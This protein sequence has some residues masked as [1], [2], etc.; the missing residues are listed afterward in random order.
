MGCFYT[1]AEDIFDFDAMNIFL[2]KYNISLRGKRFVQCDKPFVN[3]LQW[4]DSIDRPMFDD[5]LKNISYKSP[6]ARSHPRPQPVNSKVNVIHLRLEPDAIN[7]WSAMN[8]MNTETFRRTLEG[9]YIKSIKEHIQPTDYNIVVSNCQTNA[10]LEFLRPYSVVK[11]EKGPYRELNAIADLHLAKLC[12]NVF[13]GNF[14]LEKLNGSTFSYYISQIAS[15]V[16]MVMIDLDRITD[17]PKI[18]NKK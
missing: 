6:V 7:H 14:N 12:N 10:V 9:L 15:P 17:E 5:I 4:I 8:G 2:K 1:P 3:T 16:K 13:I 11:N 18:H